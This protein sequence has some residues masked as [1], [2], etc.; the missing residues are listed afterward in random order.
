M[1]APADAA[2]DDDDD[3]EDDGTGGDDDDD[4]DDPAEPVKNIVPVEEMCEVDV[5]E[6]S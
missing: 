5:A 4:D 2:M 6:D 3:F 1:Q